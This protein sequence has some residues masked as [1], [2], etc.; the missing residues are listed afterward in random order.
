MSVSYAS[1]AGSV[2]WSNVSSRPTALSSFTDDLGSSPT[3]THSQYLTSHQSVVNGGNTASWGSSVTVGTVGGTAL[4]FTMPSNPDTWRPITDSY[5]G[6]SQ[7]TSF[8]Q[9]GASRLRSLIGDL[10][11]DIE[12]LDYYQ[13]Q[14]TLIY[15]NAT[16][17]SS[18][19]LSPNRY[20]WFAGSAGTVIFTLPDTEGGYWYDED[21]VGIQVIIRLTTGSSPAITFEPDNDAYE[22]ISYFKNFKIEPN[23]TYEI[24]CLC[25]KHNWTLACTEI[26]SYRP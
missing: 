7:T 25:V 22:T 16:I 10:Q 14:R 15:Y 11:E 2:A 3:H 26:V 18:H 5:S 24:H 17:S 4:T 9:Y 1:S 8:S 13:C 20:Y 21:R 19:I 6:A 12:H 23:K